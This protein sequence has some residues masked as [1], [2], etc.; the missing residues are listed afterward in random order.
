MGIETA[1]IAASVI[2]AGASVG[3]SLLAKS[4]QKPLPAQPKSPEVASRA[5]DAAD[6]QRR[7]AV[8]AYGRSDTIL[9]SPLGLTGQGSGTQKTL[10]GA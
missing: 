3:T 5:A 7:K 2:G 8:G 10:L 9:T 1:L 6:R 4:G